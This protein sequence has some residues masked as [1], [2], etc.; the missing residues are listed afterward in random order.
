MYLYKLPFSY[1]LS[2]SSLSKGSYLGQVLL[3]PLPCSLPPFPHPL[4]P[5]LVSDFHPSVPLWLINLVGA[6]NLL[7]GVLSFQHLPH[8]PSLNVQESLGRGAERI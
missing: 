5:V 4:S 1:M 8:N 7:L 3:L 2:V 6:E